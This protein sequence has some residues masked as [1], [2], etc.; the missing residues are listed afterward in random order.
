[1][2]GLSAVPPLMLPAVPY[3]Y[4]GSNLATEANNWIN[5]ASNAFNH[6]PRAV[7]TNALTVNDTLEALLCETKVAQLLGA[8][9]SNWWTNITLFPFRVTDAGR[10]NP[11]QALLLS[12]EMGTTNQPG[13]KLQTM[14]A[15][16]SNRV[17]NGMTAGITNLRQVVQDIYRIDSLLNNS[18]PATFAS[19]VDEVRYFLWNGTLDSNYLYWARTSNALT[20]ATA[21]A[22]SVL[23]SVSPRPTTNVLLV[24]RPDTLGGP[25]RILDLNGGGPTY[26]LLD[27][28][29]LPL[30]F[31]NNFQL[32]PGSLVEI[33]GY[34]DVTNSSCAYPAIEVT[35]ALLCSVPI[36]TDADGNGNLLIDTWE[37]R[38]FGG[39]GLADPF[40]DDDRDGYSN[41]QEM[42]EGS[43][44]RDVRGIPSVAPAT[45]VAPVLTFS[46]RSGQIELHFVWPA[47]YINR[48]DFGIRH[49]PSL[50]APFTDLSATGPIQVMGDEFKMTFAAPATPQHFYYVTISLH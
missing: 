45:F 8:R 25:C 1:M 49:T 35:S 28:G 41:L 23:A 24:A 5:T 3:V 22:V 17:E 15:T 21:G 19:P 30:G 47:Y 6:L 38:F 9:G 27:A 33:S 10:T 43:D 7:V 11:S 2:I 20:S 40:A 37:K 29:G 26:A 14:F 31:P 42:L 16:I 36:A 48:F 39:L 18:N 32:L 13:Y 4:G 44:P 12:L 46:E 34:T 50:R